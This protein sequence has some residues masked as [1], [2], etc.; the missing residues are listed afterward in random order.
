MAATRPTD[1]VV[2]REFAREA[3][4]ALKKRDE[5]LAFWINTYNALV[6][7]G[8]LA[9]EIRETVWEVPDFFDRISYRIG[10]MLFSANDIE[11]GVLRGNRPDPISAVVPFLVDDP[12]RAHAIIPLDPRIHFA[13]N[14]GAR[15]C[16][17]ARRFHAQRLNEQL[18]TATRAFVNQEV[19]LEGATLTAS[20]IFKWF[21]GDFA[22]FP[23]GLAGFFA[24][25]LD[26]GPVRN[27]VLK[28]GITD[29]AWRPYDW[30]LHHP[31]SK[32][33]GGGRWE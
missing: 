22:D 14:C 29:V 2:L 21:R 5:R 11:H 27:T 9:L 4:D 30:T 13:I 32:D 24:H 3:L 1:R 26:D 7:E 33:T 16:P 12:R 17:P 20:Q 10:K 15:S 31:S 19:S 23:G 6:V 18:D 28:H 8:I 25:Y